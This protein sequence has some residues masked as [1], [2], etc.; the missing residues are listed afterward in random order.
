MNEVKPEG[1][2]RVSGRSE[3]SQNLHRE[4]FLSPFPSLF[5]RLRE[6]LTST[7]SI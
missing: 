7:P 4:R 1:M 3:R 5:C 6:G 2:G